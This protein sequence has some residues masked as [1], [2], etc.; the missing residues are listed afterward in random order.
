MLIQWWPKKMCCARQNWKKNSNDDKVFFFENKIFVRS[1]FVSQNKIVSFYLFKRKSF[2]LFF[3]CNKY[4]TYIDEF[5]VLQQKNWFRMIENKNERNTKRVRK[6]NCLIMFFCCSRK[7][8]SISTSTFLDWLIDD[9]EKGQ[10]RFFE[11]WFWFETKFLMKSMMMMMILVS[12]WNIFFFLSVVSF[13][14]TNQPNKTNYNLSYDDFP[15]PFLFSISLVAVLYMVNLLFLSHFFFNEQYL[16]FC[17]RYFFSS[18]NH[19]QYIFDVYTCREYSI[20]YI[21]AKMKYWFPSSIII[22]IIMYIKC[23]KTDYH[24]YFFQ[25]NNKQ[26]SKKERK[27]PNKK[28]SHTERLYIH[29]IH[30]YMKNIKIRMSN[31]CL[32]IHH[33]YYYHHND[34]ESI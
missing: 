31:I 7:Q 32:N 23:I 16:Y 12:I 4:T 29:W 3:T 26:Q 20:F 27:I 15:G 13:K 8:Y 34:D 18:H 2:S 1:L 9:W 21:F 10:K 30:S 33:H 28:L 22:I 24:H 11:F 25:I 17:W 14:S 19:Q 5:W 6:K